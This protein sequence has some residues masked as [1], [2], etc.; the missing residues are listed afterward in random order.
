VAQQLGHV[1]QYLNESQSPPA[2]HLISQAASDVNLTLIVDQHDAEKISGAL[3][4][5]ILETQGDHFGPKFE[6]LMKQLR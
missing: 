2:V 6:D 1:L 3:H 5:R 4:D